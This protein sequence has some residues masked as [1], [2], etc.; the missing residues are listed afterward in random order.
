M[1]GAS[2]AP[3]RLDLNLIALGYIV[4]GTL[5]SSLEHQIGRRVAPLR[6][7]TSWPPRLGDLEIA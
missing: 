2:K 1:Q 5:N 3:E 7:A 4:V 6:R